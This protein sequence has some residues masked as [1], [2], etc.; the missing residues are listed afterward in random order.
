MRLYIIFLFAINLFTGCSELP[1]SSTETT[2]PAQADKVDLN[3]EISLDDLLPFSHEAYMRQHIEIL[4]S[5]E[6]GGRLPASPGEEKT[7]AHLQAEFKKLGLKPGNGDSFFQEV[8]LVSVTAAS[9]TSMAI[10]GSA[11]E[12]SLAYGKDMIVWT[13]RLVET[14]AVED[15][16]LVFIGYGTV[17]PEFNW[18]DYDE[19]DVTGKTVVMLVNDPGYATQ[20]ENVFGGNTMT[21]YGRWTYKFEEAARQGA[22]GALIIHETAPAGYGWDVVS[23]SWSG[24]QFDLRAADNHMSRAA[25]EGWL[26]RDAAEQLLQQTGMLLEDLKKLAIQP[27]FKA[28]E[29][30]ISIS[31]SV[32]NS[33]ESSV[34]NNVIAML[35]GNQ[36]PD[37]LILYTA[38]WDH[39]GTDTSLA[40][41]DKIY[42]G[43]LDNASGTAGLLTLAKAFTELDTAP[44]R[45]IVFLAVTAEEQGLLGSEYYARNPVYPLNK[46]V[47]VMNM[48]GMNVHGATHDITVVG[49]GGSELETYLASAAKYQNRELTPEPTP[50]K[51]FFYRSDHFSLAKVGVPALYAEGGV[52]MRGRD[53][54]WGMLQQSDYITHRYHK[55]ADN[56]DPSWDLRGALEDL[57]LYIHIG[58]TLSMN[59]DFPKWHDTQGAFKQ[60]REASLTL[61]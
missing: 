41:E 50:E 54:E 8:P 43:A 17:A 61:Q 28:I 24:P 30:P 34:S 37:E 47:A 39:L 42:N 9:D 5:D 51:G 46:T 10:K 58:Y 25:I 35:P 26:T 7:I 55:P 32:D 56:Y 6:F 3:D 14:S 18:N 12:T 27:D 1:K 2:A 48:D 53:P 36:Q 33:I 19:V 29:L 16:P 22:A 45:S 4:A 49:Y 15:S 21:Y 11:G 13:K 31:V 60:A 40:A 23:N 57:Q 52:K 20:D 59:D 44:A 38:H